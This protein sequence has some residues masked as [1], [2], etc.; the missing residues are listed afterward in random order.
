MFSSELICNIIEY[1]HNNLNKEITI[2][3]LS[4]IFYYN[5]TY[6]MKK[7]KKDLGI[8][9]H[10]YI[11]T[12][13]IYNSLSYFKDDVYFLSIAFRNGFNSLEY[14][15]ETFKKIVGVSPTIYKKYI[16]HTGIIAKTAEEK[17]LSSLNNIITI[18]DKAIIYL[19]HK[20][21]KSTPIKQIIIK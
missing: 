4:I 8:S 14:F 1:I 17:I 20:K 12:L 13:R 10:N 5:K 2:D 6:I 11:N 3:E 16:N 15:S 9:I 7:F 18:R 21:P 19:A